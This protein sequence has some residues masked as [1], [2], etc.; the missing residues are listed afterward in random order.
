MSHPVPGT[1]RAFDPALL[2]LADKPSESKTAPEPN[3]DTH[4]LPPRA[5]P[6]GSEALARASEPPTYALVMWRDEGVAIRPIEVAYEDLTLRILNDL[7]L[8]GYRGNE[9]ADRYN[10]IHAEIVAFLDRRA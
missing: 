10:D 9:L 2:F 8:R 3:G 6:G 5:I 1:V 7:A 4:P